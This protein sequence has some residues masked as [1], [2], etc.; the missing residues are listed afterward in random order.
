[1]PATH[2]ASWG[3]GAGSRC[4]AEWSG[5]STTKCK[6]VKNWELASAPDVSYGRHKE[7]SRF[8][9]HEGSSYHLDSDVSQWTGQVDPLFVPSRQTANKL[10]SVYLT[11]VHPLF[12]IIWKQSLFDD[13]ENVYESIMDPTV[14][15]DN[16]CWTTL[17]LVFAIGQTF[18]SLLGEDEP[19]DIDH[20][21]YFSR[22]RLLGALD[23]VSG[24]STA[25][26]NQLQAWG[27]ASMYLLAIQH[28]NKLVFWPH[29]SSLSLVA[30][31]MR[32]QGVEH[33]RS[34]C[35]NGIWSWAGKPPGKACAPRLKDNP[36][37]ARQD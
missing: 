11:T 29:S 19:E 20:T 5:N 9:P 32:D 16:C 1:M 6:L 33:C 8:S 24:I 31:L 7:R 21:I 10:I 15:I 28:T 26:L 4:F 22:A 27:L 35:S 13:V 17:N 30:M 37:A 23:G 14:S 18:L 36:V 3:K 34:G 12:P 2:S 25:T